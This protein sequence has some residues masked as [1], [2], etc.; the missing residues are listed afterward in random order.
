MHCTSSVYRF[1]GLDQVYPFVYELLLFST[2]R[3]QSVYDHQ[4]LSTTVVIIIVI[5]VRILTAVFSRIYYFKVL[6]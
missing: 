3:V 2:I 4:R 6:L 1:A 5:I